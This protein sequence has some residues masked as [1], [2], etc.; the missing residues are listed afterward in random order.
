MSSFTVCWVIPGERRGWKMS[1]DSDP[2]P[3]K[4]HIYILF[5]KLFT[6]PVQQRGGWAAR[7]V[8]PVPAPA[9]G[10]GLG[11]TSIHSLRRLQHWG[12]GHAASREPS[13]ATNP[14]SGASMGLLWPLCRSLLLWSPHPSP[15][16]GGHLRSNKKWHLCPYQDTP[17][18]EDPYR[19]M[20]W[21]T[22][23][24]W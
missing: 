2:W 17:L 23:Q 19:N 22:W 4:P 16:A 9:P 8:V 10:S 7:F 6:S 21:Q 5:L 1:R 20:D 24:K 18:C 14:S 12:S 15:R 13:A 11:G 3:K